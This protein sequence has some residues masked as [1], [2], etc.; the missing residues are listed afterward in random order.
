MSD[1]SLG[2]AQDDYDFRRC[3]CCGFK[4]PRSEIEYDVCDGC[5]M[6]EES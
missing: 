1:Y 3:D 2:V 6:K 5:W 4:V